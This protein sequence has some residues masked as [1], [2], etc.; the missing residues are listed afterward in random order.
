LYNLK[1]NWQTDERYLIDGGAYLVLTRKGKIMFAQW[2]NY[3]ATFVTEREDIP[4]EWT[5]NVHR[6]AGWARVDQCELSID[7][8]EQEGQ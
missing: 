8:P 3:R 5:E 4:G 7:I 2:Q 6:P 1:I